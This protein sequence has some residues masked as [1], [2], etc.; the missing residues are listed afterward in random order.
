LVCFTFDRS[1]LRQG[2]VLAYSYG[3]PGSARTEW[4]EPIELTG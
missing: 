1:I 2:A 3:L 4:S